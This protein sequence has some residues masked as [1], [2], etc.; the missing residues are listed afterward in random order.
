MTNSKSKHIESK[1]AYLETI[2]PPE[3]VIKRMHDL[4][5]G[6]QYNALHNPRPH[7]RV[8]SQKVLDHYA[9][10]VQV[11]P[12]NQHDAIRHIRGE[13]REL[14][15][16]RTIVEFEDPPPTQMNVFNLLAGLAAV[17]IFFVTLS[18]FPDIDKIKL[19]IGLI[20]WGLIF[21]SGSL[22]LYKRL[23]R[24]SWDSMVEVVDPDINM[25][26]TVVQPRNEDR[27]LVTKIKKTQREQMSEIITDEEE[28]QTQV[29]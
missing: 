29:Q 5:S 12:Y 23:T 20:V 2:L 19:A 13:V 18:N 4:L 25:I 17:L 1:P 24:S 26:K 14:D 11:M 27:S 28:T 21:V 16:G 3:L 8:K 10:E 6:E 7:Y 22:Y 15:I 9:F